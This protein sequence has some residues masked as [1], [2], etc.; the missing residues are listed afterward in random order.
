MTRTRS[1]V[2]APMPGRIMPVRRG[3][4]GLQQTNPSELLGNTAAA[5]LKEKLR[6]SPTCSPRS[7]DSLHM[8]EARTGAKSARPRILIVDDDRLL[9]RA[10]ERQLRDAPIDLAIADNA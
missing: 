1:L 6:E 4:A 7:V 3:Q 8:F 10:H 5:D 9:L 2:F